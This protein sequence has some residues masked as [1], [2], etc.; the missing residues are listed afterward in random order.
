MS[1][2]TRSSEESVQ[3]VTRSQTETTL[4]SHIIAQMDF[5]EN[6][7]CLSLEE[8]QSA[9]WNQ[10]EQVTLHPI[11]FYFGNEE[12]ELSHKSSLTVSDVL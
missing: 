2:S 8:V 3:R 10:A 1:I 6:C 4:R 11:V 5:A 9:Y 7:S 12:E